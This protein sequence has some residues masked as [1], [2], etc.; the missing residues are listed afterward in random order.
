VFVNIFFRV[1]LVCSS[2]VLQKFTLSAQILYPR[3]T[4]DPQLPILKSLAPETV[5]LR[6][7]KCYFQIG[8]SYHN[9]GMDI[10][11]F[12]HFVMAREFL[13]KSNS[14]HHIV[15]SMTNSRLGHVY[16]Y[17]GDFENSTKSFLEWHFHPRKHEHLTES[18]Y[19]TLGLALH[20]LEQY[21]KSNEIF[22]FGLY[23]ANKFDSEVWK[24]IIYGNIA[25]N[26]EKIGDFKSALHC[27]NIA[28]KISKNNYNYSSQIISLLCIS[29]IHITN[30]DWTFFEKS[31]PEILELHA[32]EGSTP[33]PMFYKL[34]SELY[35]IRNKPELAFS[36]YK[37]FTHL[38]DSV[39]T[40]K[41]KAKIVELDF[42]LYASQ[43]DK[44][45]E[46][47]GGVAKK[48]RMKSIGLV[49]LVLGIFGLAV[50]FKMYKW[51]K[52]KELIAFDARQTLIE[53]ELVETNMMLEQS[54][55]EIAQKNRLIH[56]LESMKHKN[57]VAD[58][59]L[60][61]II[62]QLI[63]TKI[64]TNDDWNEFKSLFSEAYP[65]FINNI[66]QINP[67]ITDAELRMACMLRLNLSNEQ[68]G[69]M[70]GISKDSA[71]KNSLRLRNKL[72]LECDQ[73]ELMTFLFSIEV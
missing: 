4:K 64:L 11:S 37:K 61:Q 43:T 24:G 66:L 25:K 56:Y 21:D 33:L 31:I 52:E 42:Q 51:R 38:Q 23:Y 1:F 53:Q 7:A 32:I 20:Y 44:V 69:N 47:M 8:N 30:N 22:N 70:L 48:S 16:F 60:N 41:D 3:V 55:L 10:K 45:L 35:E 28:Y 19:N 13:Q 72:G 5:P 18:Y 59:Q 46:S 6:Q 29:K 15:Y 62:D 40:L 2:I 26:H 36:D 57:P 54:V 71:R 49:F 14:K 27:Y 12:E 67:G 68:I 73:A 65:N 34:R 58:E 39:K 63:H 17:F 9:K 50:Y